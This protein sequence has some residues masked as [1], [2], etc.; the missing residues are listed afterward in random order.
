MQNFMEVPI[1]ETFCGYHTLS[2]CDC[3]SF[4]YSIITNI[5]STSVILRSM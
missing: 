2:I 1:F 5:Q 4:Y 3:L